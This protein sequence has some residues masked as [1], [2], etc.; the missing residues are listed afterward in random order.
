MRAHVL[1]VWLCGGLAIRSQLHDGPPPVFAP[2]PVREQAPPPLDPADAKDAGAIANE[3]MRGTWDRAAIERIRARLKERSLADAKRVFGI[4]GFEAKT[5]NAL[6]AAFGGSDKMYETKVGRRTLL[7]L[8]FVKIGAGDWEM[9]PETL[10]N[11]RLPHHPRLP[12]RLAPVGAP[13]RGQY[14]RCD[15]VGEVRFDSHEVAQALRCTL[16]FR[17]HRFALTIASDLMRVD[18]SFADRID[19]TLSNIPAAH[20]ARVREI[21]LDPGDRPDGVIAT[22]QGTRINLFLAGAGK[23]VPQTQLDATTAHEVGH[24]ISAQ[25]DAGFW[26]RWSAAIARDRLFVSRYAQTDEHEDFAETYLLYLGGGRANAEA[27][28]RFS[29]RFAILDSVF[30]E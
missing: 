6:G 14:E 21:V 11:W 19:A 17:E 12:S 4:A 7:V 28:A 8:G 16:V 5:A 9:T 2:A 1:A 15:D 20:L 29:R 26:E 18:G 30:E 25:R 22:A 10:E 3:T 27:R 24:V 23:D 13:V